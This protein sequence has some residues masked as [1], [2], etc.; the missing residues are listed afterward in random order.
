MLLFSRQV[1]RLLK[2]SWAAWALCPLP[3]GVLRG[4]PLAQ[5]RP[6]LLPER[7]LLQSTLTVPGPKRGCPG[8]W[9]VGPRHL[10]PAIWGLWVIPATPQPPPAELTDSHASH[11]A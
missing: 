2:A 1:Y 5:C 7:T 4:L 6:G 11:S 9:T 3:S 8:L 10:M